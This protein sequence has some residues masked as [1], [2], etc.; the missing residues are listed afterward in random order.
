MKKIEVH[1][2]RGYIL[3]SAVRL[4]TEIVFAYLQAR[5]F[6]FQVP[7]LYEVEYLSGQSLKLRQSTIFLI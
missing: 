1:L 4:G 6:G 7:E 2:C 5:L 3:Q